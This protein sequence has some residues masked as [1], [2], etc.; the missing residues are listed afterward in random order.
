MSLVLDPSSFH[1]Q[2]CVPGDSQNARSHLSKIASSAKSTRKQRNDLY[3]A[4]LKTQKI[5]EAAR[6]FHKNNP[7]AYGLARSYKLQF[8]DPEE[9]HDFAPSLNSASIS[10]GKFGSPESPVKLNGYKIDSPDVDFQVGTNTYTFESSLP[11]TVDGEE[12]ETTVA[13]YFNFD[14]AK[15]TG[16]LHVDN[17]VFA[18]SLNPKPIKYNV[19]VSANT[20]AYWDSAHKKLTWDE[21]S[22]AW[23]N[24]TWED[25]M[26]FGY[27]TVTID[28]EIE[29]RTIIENYFTDKSSEPAT[30]FDLT[31]AHA[32]EYTSTLEDIEGKLVLCTTADTPGEAPASRKSSQVKSV[33][34]ALFV[35][36]FSPFGDSFSG[37]Y[38]DKDGNVYAAQGEAVDDDISETLLPELASVDN[39]APAKDIFQFLNIDEKKP[40]APEGTHPSSALNIASIL[41]NDP[42]ISDKTDP[43]QYSDY[44]AQLAMKD[45]HD[46][47]V[48]Y[49]DTNLREL[50][51]SSTPPVL[52]PEIKS[53]ADTDPEKASAFYKKLQ[54]PYLT[55][56]LASST[57]EEGKK[58]NGARAEKL[59]KAI[60]SEDPVYKSQSSALYRFRYLE[61]FP[62]TKLF[63]DEQRSGDF[64]SEIDKIANVMKSNLEE[65]TEGLE[66]TNPDNHKK[67]IESSKKHIDGLGKWAKEQ[68]LYWAF[69]LL[70]YVERV[71]LPTWHNQYMTGHGSSSLGMNVKK[72]N[73]LFSVLEN[74]KIN[75]AE[76]G[77]NFMGAY[78]EAIRAF[79]MT[80][81]IPQ[82]VDIDRNSSDFDSIVKECLHQFWNNYKDSSDTDLAK[83]A[84]DAEELY[85][86]DELRKKFFQPLAKAGRLAQSSSSWNVML[87]MWQD[88]VEEADWFK[89][90]QG[91]SKLFSALKYVMPAVLLIMPFVPGL[92][93]SMSTAEKASWG[94]AAAGIVAVI[95]I[96]IAQGAV[97]LVSLWKDISGFFDALKCGLGFEK[98]V[99]AIPDA[100]NKISGS[101][102]KY[103]SR[104]AKQTLDIAKGE[105]ALPEG[106]VEEFSRL[107]KIF[108]R[109][110]GELLANIAGITLAI[111][112]LVMTGI[113]LSK[114]DDPLM[115]AADWMMILSAAI[116]TLC[117]VAGWVVAS[118]VLATAIAVTSALTLLSTWGGPLGI[119]FALVGVIVLIVWMSTHKPQN[120]VEKFLKDYVQPAGLYM[121]HL[122]IDYFDA[123]AATDTT[124][125]RVGVCI[126]G[127]SAG[128]N[129]PAS[130]DEQVYIHLNAQGKDSASLDFTRVLEYT[131]DTVWSLQTNEYGKSQIYTQKYVIGPDN[132]RKRYVWYLAVTDDEKE[133]YVRR[134]PEKK[135]E[136]KYKAALKFTQWDVNVI[137]NPVV[138]G[139]P[140]KSKKVVQA[141]C[142]I[143][144]ET[145]AGYAHFALESD[146]QKKTPKKFIL[147]D[148]PL[149]MLENPTSTTRH[150]SKW[151]FSLESLGPVPFS[152]S[153]NPWE[154]FTDQKNERNLALFEESE[155][156]STGYKWTIDPALPK[157]DLEL[158]TTGSNEG[159]I[160]MKPGVKPELMAKTKYT[161]TCTLTLNGDPHGQ[162][163]ATVDIEITNPE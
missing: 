131:T 95:V 120:P 2:T 94:V 33:F 30:K 46:I 162:R 66:K 26:Q 135:E 83:K 147:S 123:I 125:S 58:S 89:A 63:L 40:A 102:A 5:P 133:I 27:G 48:Y 108:G 31:E 19:K 118:E 100:A 81:I 18:V 152:Y 82:L 73:G 101:F 107:S 64:S 37:A 116:Q 144:F 139:D 146:P 85:S 21:K 93:N 61:K 160:Q 114:E 113:A 43:S 110:V 13:G 62:D 29:P 84:I 17:R 145:Q 128:G 117:M 136:E 92:W 23:K 25:S 74:D 52:P 45:F 4:R 157:D 124:A 59:L 79:Q 151:L 34:P 38:K 91:A 41:G 35:A 86:N 15:P 104:T 76:G 72:L 88:L 142:S 115:I 70:Y 155:A 53:I 119:L 158:V 28:D 49:M 6:E 67:I 51:I 103:F 140:E 111:A 50:F 90:L 138:D 39:G 71:S 154:I 75:T 87:D 112:C 97:R 126:R 159:M 121:D 69:R 1:S 148:K 153:K 9:S 56:M 149:S 24:A 106:G 54:V 80:S 57:V 10:F 3:R 122:A 78:N 68:R 99:D 55:C 65:N 47:I 60:P 77:I 143:S 163:E 161:V 36:N 137:T 130:P 96:K 141:L 8:E 127:A 109:N 44:I 150:I 134:L 20:K 129:E 105:S 132:A 14:S 156:T 42:M 11:L 16:S 32:D 98:V 12:R 7:K 22:E